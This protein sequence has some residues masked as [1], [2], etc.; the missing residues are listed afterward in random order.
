MFERQSKVMIDKL[1]V[2]LAEKVYQDVGKR[3]VEESK[4]HQ[5]EIGLKLNQALSDWEK[6]VEGKLDE[7]IKKKTEK[8][9]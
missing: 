4:E 2:V 1:S 3:L 8:S 6:R 9:L 7:I 5:K